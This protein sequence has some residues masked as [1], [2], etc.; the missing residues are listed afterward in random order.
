MLLCYSIYGRVSNLHLYPAT[1]VCEANG[2]S[3]EIKK[4]EKNHSSDPSSSFNFC[5][6]KLIILGSSIAFPISRDRFKNSIAF[7]GSPRSLY[8]S[9]DFQGDFLLR[10]CRLF[11][12]KFSAP[13]R[14][15][16]LLFWVRP[17]HRML[18]PDFRGRFPSPRLSPISLEIF[19]A[20]S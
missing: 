18:T 15:I 9:P 4:E 16:Q 5:S 1:P 2:F 13:V 11:L 12:L 3:H 8:A 17:D 20:C 14:N 6:Q 10:V 19:R 7:L